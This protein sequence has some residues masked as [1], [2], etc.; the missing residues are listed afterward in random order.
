MGLT[1]AGFMP[2][3]S[4]N[5]ARA[6][7]YR[8][9]LTTMEPILMQRDTELCY[10][11]PCTDD[12][13][14][15]SY[16]SI[17]KPAMT[18]YARVSPDVAQSQMQAHLDH[19]WEIVSGGLLWKAELFD[20]NA[21]EVADADEFRLPMWC[22]DEQAIARVVELF[23]LGCVDFAAEK[24]NEVIELLINAQYS[25]FITPCFGEQ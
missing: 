20:N 22:S 14:S 6:S 4:I 10:W 23:E 5:G 2:H 25:L 24:T 19:G 13:V 16:G 3:N 21:D 18:L 1:P 11:L 12:I 7:A 9:P 15:C 8:L 17:E